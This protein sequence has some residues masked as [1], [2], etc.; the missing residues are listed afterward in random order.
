MERISSLRK[1]AVIL[2][3]AVI[4][5]AFSVTIPGNQ[6][7]AKTAKVKMPTK[8][9]IY[10][11]VDGKMVK[12]A[13]TTLKYNKKGDL[14]KGV[15]KTYAEGKVDE[16]SKYTLK[17]TYKKGKKTKVKVTGPSDTYTFKLDKSGRLTSLKRYVDDSNETF[18]F[19]YGKKGYLKNIKWTDDNDEY[20]IHKGT[21]KYKTTLKKGKASK[22]VLTGIDKDDSNE[23]ETKT[24]KIDRRYNSKELLTK[25]I[26]DDATFTCS[27]TFKKG[28]VTVKKIKMNGAQIAT[29]K[30]SYGK[31]KAPKTR[32]IKM[33]NGDRRV[34]TGNLAFLKMNPAFW[35]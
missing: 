12:S 22:I 29:I 10:E 7:I 20:Y 8:I 2:L 34:I 32:Y 31:I 13:V 9:T 25:S 18:T 28:L 27:Y 24:F 16:T 15:T 6:A 17:N 11:N 14:T 21:D 33:L 26:T 19:A 23:E 4:A 3:C 5:V 1:L 35:M 30:Y